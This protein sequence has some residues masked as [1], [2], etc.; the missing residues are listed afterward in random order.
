[1]EISEQRKL[2][3]QGVEI[4]SVNFESKSRAV[5]SEYS[6]NVKI[7][8]KIFF[9]KDDTN[10]FFIFMLV[11]VSTENL[12]DLSLQAIGRFKF[13]GEPLES[14]ERKKL[15]NA[16]STAIMFPY[17]RSFIT[18]FTAN[19][20]IFQHPIILP[21]QFFSG[22]MEEIVFENETNQQLPE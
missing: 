18:T 10:S 4:P 2:M 11:F 3:F 20:G 5:K 7:E 19:L 15:I 22:N 9:P 14:E 6:V 17:V 13:D 1:M 12:F 16:N 21:A 8:P